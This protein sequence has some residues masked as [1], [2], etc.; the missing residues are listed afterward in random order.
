MSQEKLLWVPHG[1]TTPLRA[2]ERL[3]REKGQAVIAEAGWQ[4]VIL[5]K[6]GRREMTPHDK[7]RNRQRNLMERCI[8]K[9]KKSVLGPFGSAATTPA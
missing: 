6:S 4:A 8:V 9:R 5:S 7:E 2:A 3:R 1:S